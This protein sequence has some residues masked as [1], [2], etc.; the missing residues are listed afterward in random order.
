[1]LISYTANAFPKEYVP[2]VFDNYSHN[3]SVDGKQIRVVRMNPKAVKA[4][5]LYGQAD[6]V[7]GEWVKGVFASIWE[8]YNNRELPYITWITEDGPVDAIWIEDLV[9]LAPRARAE[10]ALSAPSP[11]HR[12]LGRLP[13]PAPP[14]RARRTRCWTTTRS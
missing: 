11:P 8:K 9:S 4:P 12:N 6:P 7:S 2:T 14:L 3:V 13:A 5:Q 1:M 10:A